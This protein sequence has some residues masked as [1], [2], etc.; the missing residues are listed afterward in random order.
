MR[1]SQVRH[2][3]L[4][5]EE[6][7]VSADRGNVHAAREAK[8][9]GPGKFWGAIETAPRGG[10]V[11]PVGEEIN[12]AKARVRAR[13]EPPIWVGMRKFGYLKT[14]TAAGTQR[15]GAGAKNALL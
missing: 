5:G 1:V 9:P 2:E 14:L 7:S 15:I 13:V 3:L 12:Q 11:H 10:A 4:H 8:L 6:T